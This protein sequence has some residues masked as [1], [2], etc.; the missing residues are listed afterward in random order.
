[1]DTQPPQPGESGSDS[2]SLPG[3]KSNTPLIATPQERRHQL[4]HRN[5]ANPASNITTQDAHLKNVWKTGRNNYKTHH[6]VACD[7]IYN[8][9]NGRQLTAYCIA[10]VSWELHTQFIAARDGKPPW[11]TKEFVRTVR[12]MEHHDVFNAVMFGDIFPAKHPR[13]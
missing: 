1:M 5:A 11:S 3:A 6:A 2:S 4:V 8:E 13:K 12:E 10:G 7:Y 9:V